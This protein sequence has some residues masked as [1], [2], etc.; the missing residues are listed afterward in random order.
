M[1]NVK[2][3]L[4]AATYIYE[5][6]LQTSD[7]WATWDSLSVDLNLIAMNANLVARDR[8]K[9]NVCSKQHSNKQFRKFSPVIFSITDWMDFLKQFFALHRGKERI[10][11]Q[12][13]KFASTVKFI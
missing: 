11:S 13:R 12:Y 4:N 1:N 2:Y 6:L 8:S 3:E 9:R 10:Y 7:S 5:I